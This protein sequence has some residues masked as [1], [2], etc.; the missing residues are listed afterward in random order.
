[1]ELQNNWKSGIYNFAVTGYSKKADLIK[2]MIYFDRM[3][4]ISF[5][6]DSI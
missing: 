3:C 4:D 1:M 5:E 6:I 2:L